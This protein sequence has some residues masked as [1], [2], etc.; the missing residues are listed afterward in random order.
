MLHFD[1][2][3]AFAIFNAPV[4]LLFPFSDEISFELI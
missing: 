3:L 2:F 4:A 1:T